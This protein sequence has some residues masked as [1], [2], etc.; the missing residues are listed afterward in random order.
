MQTVLLHPGTT[1]EALEAPGAKW[2]AAAEDVVLPSRTLAPAERVSIYHGMVAARFV[3]ALRARFPALLSAL[4]DAAFA[5]LADAYVAASPSR[6][7]TLARLGDRLPLF[8]E[9]WDGLPA[10]EREALSDLARYELAL[11]AAFDL[12][13][14]PAIGA[15]QLG[16]VP[17]DLWDG[18]RLLPLPSLR[19]LRLAH[20][21]PAAHAELE[22]ERRVPLPRRRVTLLAVWR[23]RTGV[24][25]LALPRH[26]LRLLEMLVQGRTLGGALSASP[27]AGPRAVERWLREWVGAG[28]FAGVA[29]RR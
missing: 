25:T 24:R 7:F 5:R 22:A 29:L 21:A 16:R 26:G 13:L 20:D 17:G 23:D 18:A 1:A 19:L 4:G 11:E 15:E 28:L 14:A 9:R 27:T 8:L 12:P 3:N 10:K 6:S 2:I